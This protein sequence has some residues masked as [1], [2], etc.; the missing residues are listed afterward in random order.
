MSPVGCGLWFVLPFPKATYRSAFDICIGSVVKV[1]DFF[2]L[3]R[4]SAGV[5]YRRKSVQLISKHLAEKKQTK[6]ETL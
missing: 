1:A 5:N 6:C 3:E 4:T 2:G